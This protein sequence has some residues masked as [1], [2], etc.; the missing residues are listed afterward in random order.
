MPKPIYD[1]V[2]LGAGAAGLMAAAHLKR[3]RVAILEHNPGPGAKIAISGGGRCNITN[4]DL[5]PSRYLGDRNFIAT[6]F[7]TFDNRDLL[8]FLHR[9]GLDPVIR[10]ENQY[11]C[12]NSARE[13]I[14]AL[15]RAGSGRD[16]AGNEYLYET[17]VTGAR[18]EDGLFVVESSRGP[19]HAKKLLVASGGLSYR[20]V[21][22][23]GIGLQIAEHFGHTVVPTRPAL[24]G[25]TL[26]PP[27]S[28]MTTLSGLSMPVQMRIGRRRVAGDMLFAH[29]GISGPAVLNA[30]LYWNQGKVTA[31]FLP[32]S[33]L[34]SLFKS[35]HKSAASQIPLPR[36]FVQTFFAS[37]DLP[38]IPYQ[39]MDEAQKQR[40]SLLKSYAFAPAGTFGYAKAEVTK[41]GV[42]TDEIDP[43]TM[44]SRL[45]D[46]LFFAGEVVDV[47]GE[48]G[49]YNFQ[50][51]FSSAVVAAKGIDVSQQA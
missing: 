28:W 36:R 41:G 16:F 27:Q 18:K 4:T 24:A 37:L 30:S 9:Y 39:A 31:D 2:V 14:D 13:L 49:G 12:P 29:K 40:L 23:S 3:K 17:E 33:R 46:G 42:A 8:A 7:S 1:V 48:L 51:A 50:W 35:P 25:L 32:G 47:A 22:A 45:V 20:S 10:K 19:M 15:S 34:K 38:N 21:G 26:Q 5:S 44:Q 11:F 43:H 6:V